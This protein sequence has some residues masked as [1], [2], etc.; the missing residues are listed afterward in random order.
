MPAESN[1]HLKVTTSADT[2]GLDKAVAG[3]KELE[4]ATKSVAGSVNPWTTAANSALA[5]YHRELPNATRAMVTLDSSQ[6]QATITTNGLGAA[7]GKLRSGLVGNAQAMLQL[8]RGAQDAQYGIGGMVNN[9][10]GLVMALGGG[11]GVAGALTIAAVGFDILNKNTDLFGTQSRKAKKEAE[12]LTIELNKSA[13]ASHKAADSAEKQAASES[14]RTAAI[15]AT[16]DAYEQWATALE[17]AVRARESLAAIEGQGIDAQKRLELAKLEAEIE[18]GKVSPQ[19]AQARKDDIEREARRRKFAL[20]NEKSTTAERAAEAAAV[21]ARGEASTAG[22]TATAAEQ[23]AAAMLGPDR[24][25]GL[26][27]NVK[28]L[29]EERKGLQDAINE[30]EAKAAKAKAKAAEDKYKPFGA[31]SEA[32]AQE[33]AAE[34][35]AARKR[36]ERNRQKEM[37]AW[38]LLTADQQARDSSGYNSKEAALSAAKAA[39]REQRAKTQEATGLE[40][41][42]TQARMERDARGGVYGTE[43]AALEQERQNRQA[44]ERA[45]QR[46]LSE[47]QAARAARADRESRKSALGEAG[48]SVGSLAEM[49]R[50]AGMN[51]AALAKLQQLG[52]KVAGGD[53]SAGVLNALDSLLTAFGK[54]AAVNAM[55]AGKIAKMEK[56]LNDATAALATLREGH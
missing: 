45:E 46:R 55:M 7:S 6:K 37:E 50:A 34:E 32:A 39:R 53:T 43:S 16:G 56:E 17:R 25:K 36:M 42:A 41:A 28:A 29:E 48:Q 4:Q 33:A 18:S 24:R 40:A 12:D 8:S 44:K 52:S 38:Q 47:E 19:Q 35:A 15:E 10:E 9:I 1:I 20:E 51:P 3:T 22:E 23:A 31:A 54:S 49:G 2:A 27:D 26:E 13:E 11:A 30:A 5:T 14:V 21:F